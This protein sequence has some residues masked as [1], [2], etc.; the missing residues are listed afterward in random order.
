M[1]SKDF[2]E[3]YK[4]GQR[5][6][7]DLDFEYLEGFSNNDFTDIIFE[8]CFLNLNFQ[9]S[10]LTNAQFLNCNIKDIDLRRANLTNALVKNCSVECAMFKGANVSNFKFIDNYY[11]GITLGQK[12]F[13][14]KLVDSEY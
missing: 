7:L 12:D 11:Y 8:N 1:N 4:R 5:R 9:N 13:D 3:A 2:F 10:N 14:D 6:F